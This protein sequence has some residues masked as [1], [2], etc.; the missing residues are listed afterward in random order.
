MLLRDRPLF[1]EANEIHV[2]QAT[3]LSHN[4]S[5]LYGHW[6]NDLT[7]GKTWICL[8]LNWHVEGAQAAQNPPDDMDRYIF[9]WHLE[10]IETEWLIDFADRHAQQQIIVICEY[11]HS[12]IRN[13]IRFVKY[14]CWHLVLPAVL[15]AHDMVDVFKNDRSYLLSCL[16]S[17]G[18]VFKTLAVAHLLKNYA[19]DQRVFFTWNHAYQ[20]CSKIILDQ[21]LP[22]ARLESL[23]NYYHDQMR[24]VVKTVQHLS[25]T[26]RDHVWNNYDYRWIGYDAWVNVTNETFARSNFPELSIEM[27]PGP[28]LSEKTWKPLLSGSA[29]LPNGQP[30]T[31]QHLE[32][33][34]FKFEYPWSKHFDGEPGDLDRFDALLSIIDQIMYMEPSDLI[35]AVRVS[36]EHNFYHVRSQEL[37]KH[38]QSIND[39]SVGNF[40]QMV[41]TW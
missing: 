26:S 38:I 25:L 20:D 41:K 33:F 21:A 2:G 35:S 3:D 8:N 36:C 32:N 9:S 30:N 37:I 34:G 15:L 24:D 39:Q 17:K 10:P 40:L 18:S 5:L 16:A 31:Y 28:Y 23:R 12:P 29:V 1:F 27:I 6:L 4:N 7:I 11:D 19:N 14:H 22:V 13:N